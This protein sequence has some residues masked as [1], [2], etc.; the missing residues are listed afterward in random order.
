MWGRV[1][2]RGADAYD[3]LLRHN[4]DGAR[5]LVAA[6]PDGR[7]DDVL[8]VGCGTG[9]VTEAMVDRFGTRRVTGVNPS[10]GMLERFRE[11][12]SGRVDATLVV[13]GRPRH[14]RPR[15]G[16]RR[17]RERHGVPL[18]PREAGGDRGDGPAPAA[19]RRARHPGVRVGHRRRVPR[20]P[21]GR[22]PAGPR[23]VDRG[24]R[25]HP[26]ERRRGRG[27]DGRRGA[28]GHRRVGGAAGPAP[29]PRRLPR[30][31]RRRGQSSVRGARP[32]R[33]RRRTSSASP[34]RCTRRAVP[35]ASGSRS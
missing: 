13:A 26:A 30:P 31:D 18:V 17:G 6:L 16:V 27:V 22:P 3:D 23:G 11:K 1:S 29:G 14:G 20:G 24:V 12:L 21:R 28:R 19:W 33:G 34:A 32:R 5:R 4:R 10:E 2:T 7:Y 25:H 8:D 9:F 35:T 15:R